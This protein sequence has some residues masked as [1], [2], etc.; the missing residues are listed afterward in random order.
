MG[1]LIVAPLRL[2]WPNALL[3]VCVF[4]AVGCSVTWPLTSD[5]WLPSRSISDRSLATLWPCSLH[6]R[7]AELSPP[8][9]F[10]QFVYLNEWIDRRQGGW[11][12]SEVVT[13]LKQRLAC[14]VAVV[15]LSVFLAG[16]R[17]FLVGFCLHDDGFMFPRRYKARKPVQHQHGT[18]RQGKTVSSYADSVTTCP[19]GRA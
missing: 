18:M 15:V 3:S 16:K 12:G 4:H 2:L 1:C 14:C 9:L 11:A 17:L 8:A 6:W 7:P 19:V 5:R 13:H 10:R